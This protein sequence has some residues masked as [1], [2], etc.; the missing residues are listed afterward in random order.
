MDAKPELE[1]YADDVKCS[2]GTTIGDLDE[3]A[4]FYLMSRGIDPQTARAM[5]VQAFVGELVDQLPF[6]AASSLASGRG[7]VMVGLEAKKTSLSL[8]KA[9]TAAPLFF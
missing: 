5:L 7:G 6:W 4:L 1:I 3:S 2:H 8:R 9:F